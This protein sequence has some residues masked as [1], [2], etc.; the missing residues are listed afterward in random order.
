MCFSALY[1][2]VSKMENYNIAMISRCRHG[3]LVTFTTDNIID[4]VLE[5]I[6]T[7][8]RNKIGQTVRVLLGAKAMSIVNRFDRIP[9]SLLFP[10]RFN[11]K[12]NNA[13]REILTKAG[14]TRVVTVIDTK[15]RTE[16]K[17]PINEIAS[18]HMARRT[19]TGN[20]YRQV[21]DPNLVAS[22]SGHAAGSKALTMTSR[23]NSSVLLIEPINTQ[24]T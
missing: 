17:R 8:N 13:I 9:G 11:F 7:K 4:G 3:D 16:T 22:M 12:Y 23:K 18:S 15:T 24:H 5:Y 19:F 6:P 21:K 2:K 20:L 10:L 14:I 1:P